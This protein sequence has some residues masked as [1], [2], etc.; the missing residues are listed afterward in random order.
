MVGLR[1]EVIYETPEKHIEDNRGRPC[2]HPYL[3]ADL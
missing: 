2:C 3:G 1:D